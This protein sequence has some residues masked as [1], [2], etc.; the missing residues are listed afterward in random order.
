MTGEGV[1][2]LI[3]AAWPIIAK[4]RAA[5]AASIELSALA[6]DDEAAE[7]EV[8]ADYNPALVPPLRESKKHKTSRQHKSRGKK[9]SR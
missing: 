5:E 6:D 9:P 7:R 8:P 1:N 4:A 3:E 2:T